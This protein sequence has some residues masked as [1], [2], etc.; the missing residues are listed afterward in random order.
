MT[1]TSRLAPSCGYEA[2]PTLTCSGNTWWV[3]GALPVGAYVV[4]A[5][6]VDQ[7]GNQTTSTPITIYKD[8]TS[9]T[10]ASGK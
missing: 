5:V 10:Y 6:A 2:T 8:A 7:A 4:N 9:P 1:S 3:T